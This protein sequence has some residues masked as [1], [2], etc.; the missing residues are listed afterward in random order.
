VVPRLSVLDLRNPSPSTPP[1]SSTSLLA[2]D[3]SAELVV[4]ETLP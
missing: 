4:G 2:T 3:P 1:I